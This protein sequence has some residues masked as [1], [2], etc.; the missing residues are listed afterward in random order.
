MHDINGI[1]PQQLR[2]HV[3]CTD[4]F[5]R[6]RAVGLWT[7]PTPGRV[8][9]VAPPAEAALLSPD[10]ARLLA[11]HLVVFAAA[12]ERHHDALVQLTERRTG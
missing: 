2:A 8:V 6:Q 7:A 9:L 4:G 5:N 1:I 12:V 10:E 11:S 3:P